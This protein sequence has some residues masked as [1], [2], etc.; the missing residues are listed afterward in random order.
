MG[1]LHEYPN[2]KLIMLV[3]MLLG[4]LLSCFYR[5]LFHSLRVFARQRQPLVN[6]GR[7]GARTFISHLNLTLSHLLYLSCAVRE[8]DEIAKFHLSF[9]SHTIGIFTRK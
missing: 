1:F 5:V 9:F 8:M 7:G 2:N 3:C 4:S 6:T